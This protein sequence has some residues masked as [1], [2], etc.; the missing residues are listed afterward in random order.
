M[1]ISDWSSDVCSSDL[2]IRGQGVAVRVLDTV[3]VFDMVLHK[4]ALAEGLLT[5]ESLQKVSGWVDAGARAAAMRN[6]SATHLLHSALRQILGNH[7]Q[8]QGS[9]VGPERR[10]ERCVGNRGVRTG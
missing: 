3:K 5:R 10:E 6:H 2:L 7:V 9:R 4:C 1:R 8:Q